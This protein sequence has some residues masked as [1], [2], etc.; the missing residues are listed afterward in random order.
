MVSVHPIHNPVKVVALLH[1]QQSLFEQSVTQDSHKMALIALPHKIIVVRGTYNT[2]VEGW[3]V[4][5]FRCRE[6]FVKD[7]EKSGIS[8]TPEGIK[9]YVRHQLIC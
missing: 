9:N 3:L 5:V 7:Y 1:K 4:A 2:C 8:A 6:G